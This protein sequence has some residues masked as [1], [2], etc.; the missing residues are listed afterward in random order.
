MNDEPVANQQ[1]GPK[2][3]TEATSAPAPGKPALL[4]RL[5]Q[6]ASL[7]TTIG[8]VLQTLAIILQTI[9]AV[10][11]L[12]FLT[13][14]REA[15]AVS[16][17]QLQASTDPVLH[18]LP[19]KFVHATSGKAGMFDFTIQNASPSDLVDVDIYDDYFYAFNA[20]SNQLQLYVATP[21]LIIHE[22]PLST[23]RSHSQTNFSISFTN[24]LAFM[25]ELRKSHREPCR[26]LYLRLRADYRRSVDGRHFSTTKLYSVTPDFTMLV[27]DTFR[28]LPNPFPQQWPY[29]DIRNMLHAD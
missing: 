23:L 22:G 14:S 7:V 5:N 4:D 28:G 9:L 12:R 2:T 24:N 3:C 17:R 10:I 25:E 19:V 8:M 16:D 27:G 20:N 15:I 13:L 6:H 26:G 11:M 21:G 29:D 18:V 1:V